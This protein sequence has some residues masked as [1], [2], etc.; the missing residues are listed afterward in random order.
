MGL[1]LLAEGIKCSQGGLV[2]SG[3]EVQPYRP[4]APMTA[5][6]AVGQGWLDSAG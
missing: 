6:E 5:L 2:L 3:H 1:E 4:G